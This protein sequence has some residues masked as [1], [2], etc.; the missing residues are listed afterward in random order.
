MQIR[1]RS[2]AYRGEDNRL[3]VDLCEQRLWG[4]VRDE[5]FLTLIRG[6]PVGHLLPGEET[7]RRRK[8]RDIPLGTNFPAMDKGE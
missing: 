8:P 1:Q 3:V 4:L 6:D 5:P 2:I 7:R